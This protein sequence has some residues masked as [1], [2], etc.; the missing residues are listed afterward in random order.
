MSV[1]Y[2]ALAVPVFFL[3]I[4]AEIGVAWAKGMSVYRFNDSITDLGCGIGSQVTGVFVK[5]AMLAGYAWLF[6]HYR[7]VAFADGS[8]VPWVVAFFGVDFAY[9]WW[10]RLSHEVAF[11]WAI[12]VVHHQSE[13]YNLA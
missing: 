5:G 13:D 1:N 10:H 8:L 12:H 3:L 4:A 7:F 6:E 2:I 9:Y 11:M